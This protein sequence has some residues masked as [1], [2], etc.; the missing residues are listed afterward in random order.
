MILLAVDRK[1]TDRQLHAANHELRYQG[2]RR[3]RAAESVHI[4][5]EETSHTETPP[6]SFWI[7]THPSTASFSAA[8]RHR[9]TEGSRRWRQQRRHCVNGRDCWDRTQR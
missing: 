1:E 6:K 9:D 5:V 8:C 4:G 7:T 3:R 2:K